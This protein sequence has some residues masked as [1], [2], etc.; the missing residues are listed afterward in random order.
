MD[1]FYKRSIVLSI[2]LYILWLLIYIAVDYHYEKKYQYAQIDQQLRQGALSTTYLLPDNYH[3]KDMQPGDIS[4]EQDLANIERLSQY[5]DQHDIIYSYTLILRDNKIYF[6]SSSATQEERDSQ[7]GLSYYFD[8]Y[9]DV[10]PAVYTAFESEKTVFVEYTDKWGSFRSIYI[11]IRSPDGTLYVT[12]ADYALNEIE[13]ILKE[14]VYYSIV[15][16]FLFLLFL[17]P[18]IFFIT[19]WN[20]SVTTRISK[21]KE[22]AEQAS[23]AKT[24]FLS[25]VTHELKTPLNAILGFSHLLQSDSKEPLTPE[26]SDFV[27]YISKSGEQLLGLINEMLDLS[28][29]E[30]GHLKMDIR[31]QDILRI[32][33]QTIKLLKSDALES[34][35]KLI[36]KFSD[37][38]PVFAAVDGLRLQQV[39]LNFGSNAIKYNKLGGEVIFSIDTT[40]SNAVRIIVDDTGEGVAHN[41]LVNLFEPFNRLD[42]EQSSIPGTGIG[43]TICQKLALLMNGSVGADN[44]DEGGLRVWIDLPTHRES[45]QHEH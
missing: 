36:E 6:T 28:M 39:L 15:L 10:D 44:N 26:Q 31:E 24:E 34:D 14:G 42:K 4:L 32:I 37:D 38:I 33:K 40:K 2:L 22:S 18:L 9:E 3:H 12:A 8:H 1:Q 20:Q 41:D 35:I 11:P 43:L 45:S 25:H 29:I 5:T 21:A 7:E 13:S 19:R 30:S 17:C 23:L 27:T 16:G